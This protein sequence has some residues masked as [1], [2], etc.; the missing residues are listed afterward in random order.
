MHPLHI[1][2]IEDEV[3]WAARFQ[4]NLRAFGVTNFAGPGYDRMEITLA[5]NQRDADDA[6]RSAGPGGYDL[7]LLDLLYPESADDHVN[8]HRPLA[9]RGVNWLPQLRRHLP[10]A[11]IVVLTSY[12]HEEYLQNV[13]VAIRAH[14]A[15]DFVPKTAPIEHVAG[16]IRLARENARQRQRLAVLERE[17]LALN[18]N[19]A[20]RMYA[21][22]VAGLLQNM[23]LPLNRI[24]RQIE[25][26]DPSALA[27]APDAIRGEFQF[28]LARFDEVTQMMQERLGLGSR[29]KTP[30]DISL[31]VRDCLLLYERWIEEAAA[32]AFGP[33]PEDNRGSE[34]LWH[35]AWR[36][37]TGHCRRRRSRTCGNPNS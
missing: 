2:M 37:Q 22:D 4:D 11:T 13:V 26:R 3:D 24:A 5:S 17:A 30:T 16:R 8:T 36:T 35:A 25:T 31:A 1:L 29:C 7:V 19:R 10:G 21:E 34:N 23:R 18:R 15:D 33:D 6:V 14:L 32:V 28:V 20:A 27:K 12:A 9:L